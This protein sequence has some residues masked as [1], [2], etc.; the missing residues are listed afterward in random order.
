[1]A[2]TEEELKKE[3][4][5]QEYEY[6][7]VTEIDADTFS[8]GLSED[9]VRAISKR[10]EE[11]NWMTEWRLEAYRSWKKMKEPEWSNVKYIKPDFQE[12]SYYSAPKSKDKYESLD[13]VD[14]ELLKTFEK[15]GISVNEQ[16]KLAGVAVDIVVD[17][18]SVA[19]TFRETLSKKGIIFCSISEA[20]REYPD[21]VKK[22]IGSVIP[23]KD[24]FYS[25]LNSAVFSD[26]SFC[27]IP[28]GVRCPME[29]STYFR[30]NQAGTGQF[31]RTLV[32]ADEGSYVSY[33]E[34]CTAPSR[35][36]NQLHAAVVELIALDNA[37]IKYSTV[38]NWYPGN[39]NGK[40]GVYNFVTKRGICHTNS[41][42]SWTQVE[43][44]SAVTWKYPSC[45]LKGDNSIGEFYSIAVTNNY[46]QADT[47]TKMI[48]I[49]KNTKSTIISKGISAGKSQNSYRGL[50]QVNPRAE[51]ARNF[52]QCDSLL[53][54]NKCGAHTFPYIEVKNNTAMVE[55]EA[56]TS[57][58]GEDQILFS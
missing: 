5:T 14:P 46:Q 3:L 33:L 26:G 20:I 38:Q 50:V 1:M 31:E 6:G 17:S 11:P 34:G 57:K 47:G 53:M 4:E 29:L 28:K 9:V 51:N 36:E 12:I 32:I 52:S 2:Y 30:I 16:K 35:D 43:T 58:I 44:G 7:F 37:E 25:A 21:L 10:K 13:E 19:T 48:H 54:G 24:N 41:K 45:I 23:R 49:G 22:Y 27:Y 40:G 18:V 56:S 39:K 55:H 42:I 8:K 15:L